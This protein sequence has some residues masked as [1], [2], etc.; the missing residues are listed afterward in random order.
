[1]IRPSIT[2]LSHN[3]LSLQVMA[4][5]T[6]RKIKAR[7]AFQYDQYKRA[8]KQLWDH[9]KAA[10][11]RVAGNPDSESFSKHIDALCMH[12]AGM[13]LSDAARSHCLTPA[14]LMNFK[15]RWTKKDPT[16]STILA[17]LLEGAAI[18]ATTVFIKKADD[19]DASEAATAASTLTKAA[20]TLRQ[21]E[22]TNY[23]PTEDVALATLD[24]IATILELD[25][26][27]HPEPKQLP[28]SKVRI[29]ENGK[30]R[31]H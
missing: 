2:S 6:S 30:P 31:T 11:A 1:M 12:L 21:G 20:V 7:P 23:R 4:V 22:A 28:P 15:S 25:K 19:M 18:K 17:N 3:L 27:R 16:V 14:S 5:I 10:P 9:I 13:S 26:Q 8:E 29:L 24:R